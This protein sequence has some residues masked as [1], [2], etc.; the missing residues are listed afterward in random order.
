MSLLILAS[1]FES[2][3]KTIIVVDFVL[4]K[5]KVNF[6]NRGWRVS[7]SNERHLL[8]RFWW[9]K[10]LIEQFSK[11]FKFKFKYW[12]FCSRISFLCTIAKLISSKGIW[13]RLI[14]NRAIFQK[15]AKLRIMIKMGQT[16]PL[17]I[18]VFFSTQCQILD[19]KWKKRRW[20][21][22]CISYTFLNHNFK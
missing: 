15:M 3:E 4:K 1:F 11:K 12:F 7:F 10:F 16:R 17:L 6:S 19:Y 5:Q 2:F 13:R 18:L 14:N 9:N 8:L 22:F 21:T 20:C